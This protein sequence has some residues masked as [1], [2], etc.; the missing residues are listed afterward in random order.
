MISGAGDD[1]DDNDDNDD[2]L[3]FN[4]VTAASSS[5]AQSRLDQIEADLNIEIDAFMSSSVCQPDQIID[6]LKKYP[7]IMQVFLKHNCIRSSEAI[8]ERLFSYAGEFFFLHFNAK[9]RKSL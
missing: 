1:V 5:S 7:R 9:I 6:Y 3:I 4:N 2:L 8:C